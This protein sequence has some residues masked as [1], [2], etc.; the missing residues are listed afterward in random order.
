MINAEHIY[1]LHTS[2]SILIACTAFRVC[3]EALEGYDCHNEPGNHEQ[4][5]S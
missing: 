2:R 1:F 3:G 4:H 5:P